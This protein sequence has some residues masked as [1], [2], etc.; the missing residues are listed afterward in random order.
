MSVRIRLTES[1]N[2]GLQASEPSPSILPPSYPFS[3]S[4][5]FRVDTDDDTG[6]QIIWWYGDG[7]ATGNSL[8]L[9][10][11]N[12]ND[13]LELDAGSAYSAITTLQSATTVS[14]HEWG[15]WPDSSVL[16]CHD[17]SGSAESRAE[18]MTALTS[19]QRA[20]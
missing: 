5:W 16:M 3:V 12:T 9:Q 1:L 8:L 2:P 18:L 17:L 4:V 20:A 7:N 19:V 14:R 10:F 15:A 13:R 11:N 6:G